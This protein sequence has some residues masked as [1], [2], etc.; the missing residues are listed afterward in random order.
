MKKKIITILAILATAFSLK[1]QSNDSLQVEHSPLLET[2]SDELHHFISFVPQ[3]LIID[4]ARIDYEHRY[5]ELH[6]FVLSA[7]AYTGTLRDNLFFSSDEEE[8]RTGGSIEVLHKLYF[9]R[10]LPVLGDY[11]T[12]VY[13]AHG[14]YYQ[15][16]TISY[17]G[18]SWKDTQIDGL[19]VLQLE[20]GEQTSN[21]DKIGYS[22]IMG[23]QLIS[24]NR[25]TWEFYGGL[26]FRHSYI[27]SSAASDE[28]KTFDEYWI[29]P[30]YSGNLLLLG[31]KLGIAF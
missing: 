26:G 20:E 21:I 7:T 13:L 16:T 14:P 30:G 5:N 23:A 8:K 18:F 4:G 28:D 25:F 29:S 17:N 12:Q 27:T 1:A 15:R 2:N 31:A 24:T 11:S 6:G 19:D 9:N 10:E 3:F 22:I